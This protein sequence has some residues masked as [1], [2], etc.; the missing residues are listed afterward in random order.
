MDTSSSS[1][2]NISFLYSLRGKL[3]LL[4]LAMSLIPLIIVGTLVYTQAKNALQVEITSKLVALRDI[5][6]KQITNY[7]DERLADINV[8]S[9]NPT[10]INSIKDFEEIL[11]N[12]DSQTEA[13]AM[14]QYRPLYQG[15]PNLLDANDNSDYS[16]VHAQ[17]H[18][19]F[20]KYRDAYH[21][22]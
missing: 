14:Q 6:A 1:E 5:K 11:H 7:F 16:A 17:Y 18:P 8:L 4:F 3:I 13:T 9:E 21:Y 20:K 2:T 15:K 12:V 19:I 10:I 22:Y